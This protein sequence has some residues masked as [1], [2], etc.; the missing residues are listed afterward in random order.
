M[1]RTGHLV[2]LIREPPLKQSVAFR[3]QRARCKLCDCPAPLDERAS[4]ARVKVPAGGPARRRGGGSRML[5]RALAPG[6]I[7]CK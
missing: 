1:S 4:A 3:A 7:V 6:A 2:P 5:I